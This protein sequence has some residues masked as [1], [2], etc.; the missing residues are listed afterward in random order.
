MP[1]TVP[2]EVGDLYDIGFETRD[3]STVNVKN[4]NGNTVPMSKVAFVTS[5]KNEQE[6]A[7]ELQRKSQVVQLGPTLMD[8]EW[9]QW[10]GNTQGN[11]SSGLGQRIQ[12]GGQADPAAYWDGLGIIWPITDW[13]PQQPFK[14]PAYT[15]ASQPNP[16]VPGYMG[17]VAG[18]LPG[19]GTGVA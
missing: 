19:R 10:P 12:F 4:R 7:T 17:T 8:R 5:T 9:E 2:Q 13:L 3:G 15:D 11:W 18:F 6:E 16:G 1:F 14:P